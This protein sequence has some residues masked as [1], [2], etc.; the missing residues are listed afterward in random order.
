MVNTEIRGGWRGAFNLITTVMMLT[1]ACLL[2]WENRAQL[3]TTSRDITTPVP[4]KPVSVA[5]SPKLGATGAVAII[6]YTDFQCPF[7]AKFAENVLP[8]LKAE[9]VDANVLTVFVKNLPLEMHP[10]ARKAAEAAVCANSQGQFWEYHDF[11]FGRRP[12]LTEEDLRSSNVRLDTGA[13]ETCRTSQA[14]ADRVEHERKEA[15]T[16]GISTTPTFLLGTILPDQTVQVT[17]VLNGAKPITDFR[18]AIDPLVKKFA[19]GS[20]R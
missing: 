11:L 7:C 8:T 13:F 6:V 15:E 14:T 16:L 4:S 1:L 5:G 10:F 19:P 20:K 17:E 9:Y 3:M 2:V 12:G 18:A